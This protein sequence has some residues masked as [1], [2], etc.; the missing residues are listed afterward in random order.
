MRGVPLGSLGLVGVTW[1]GLG[2][3]SV[4][5]WGLGSGLRILYL[6]VLL[7]G[8]ITL[9]LLA[10]ARSTW[11]RRAV[12]G[13]AGWTVGVAVLLASLFPITGLGP[14]EWM[15]GWMLHAAAIGAGS[16]LLP[17]LATTLVLAV[18]QLR[19]PGTSSISE[20]SKGEES[21]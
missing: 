8:G 2:M 16:S 14:S 19:G 4:A 1:I 6:H 15:G 3:P 10:A 20:P 17:A 5:A 18:Q 7:L 12:P 21:A 9:G 13:P 11:G